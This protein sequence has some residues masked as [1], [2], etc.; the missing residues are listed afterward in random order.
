MMKSKSSY[1]AERMQNYVAML[2][3]NLKVSQIVK[4]RVN[5]ST[6]G[7]NPRKIKTC[8]HLKARTEGFTAALFIT[9]KR[10]TQPNVHRLTNG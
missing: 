9:I 7:P 2:E 4:C 8:M 6:L 3:S 5:K 1:T 10:W